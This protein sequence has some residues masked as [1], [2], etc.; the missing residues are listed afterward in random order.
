M[1]E[2]LKTEDVRELICQLCRQ[3]Y[4]M[5]WASGTGGGISIREGDKIYMAPSGAQKER[6]EP[7]E[8]Y[9]LDMEENVLETPAGDYCVSACKP[10]F[11]N[12]YRLR[13]AGAVIHSHSL[14]A[15]LAT[16]VSGNT[17]RV[18]GLEMMKGIEGMTIYDTLEV[19]VIANTPHESQLSNSMAQAMREFPKTQAVLVK[20][21]GVYV[22]GKD[23]KQAKAQAE[24][25]DYLFAATVQMHHLKLMGGNP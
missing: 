15:M 22:W 19:P 25:H 11:M 8:L 20:G 18:T 21:H 10:L 14:N 6:I 3:F 16:L 23:W 2:T 24:C 7:D 5:G 1:I 13:N 9:V 12:A 17:F 4:S